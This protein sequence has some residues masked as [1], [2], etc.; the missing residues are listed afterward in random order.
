MLREGTTV[1][2]EDFSMNRSPPHYVLFSKSGDHD[3]PGRGG[4]LYAAR[5]DPNSVRRATWSW[6]S[7]ENG[8]N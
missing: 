7:A 3:E 1:V 5:T 6:M 8:S 2:P 4:S